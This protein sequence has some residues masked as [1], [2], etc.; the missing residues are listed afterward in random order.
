MET[1]VKPVQ[2]G[3]GRKSRW[4]AEQEVGSAAQ[5]YRWERGVSNTAYSLQDGQSGG[6]AVLQQA[7][8]GGAVDKEG[9]QAVK[10]TRLSCHRFRS[11]EVRLWL[12]LIAY[13]LGNLWRRLVLPKRIE[14]WSLTSLQQRLVKTGGRL[15]THARYYWLKGRLLASRT[16]KMEI[17]T[18]IIPLE[19]CRGFAAVI[20]FLHH[21][22]LGFSPLTSGFLPQ[23]RDESSLAGSVFFALVNGPA[24]IVLFFVLSGY[25][26]TYKVFVRG[27]LNL[28]AV[29]VLKRLPR[30]AGPVVLSTIASWLL[31]VTHSYAYKEAAA[32]TGS[33]WLKEFAFAGNSDHFSPSLLDA[34]LQGAFYT[35]ITGE[36]FYN[37]NLWTMQPEFGG[38]LVSYFFATL[39]VVAF[40]GKWLSYT[41]LVVLLPLAYLSPYLVPFM[42]G[43]G[44]AAF[45]SKHLFKLPGYGALA[46]LCVGGYLLGFIIP[47]KQYML[48]RA[49][50]EQ[51]VG[52]YISLN[53]HTLTYTLGATV[54]LVGILSGECVFDALNNKFCQFLGRISFSLY[55][56]QT[57]VVCSISS[58]VYAYL[59][60][61]WDG[62]W[63]LA[64]TFITTLLISLFIAH[65]LAIFDKWWVN[66]VNLT[67]DR[68]P[69]NRSGASV[70]PRRS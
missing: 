54:I 17:P 36:H 59:R 70:G 47:D 30:L 45:H 25:V 52:S 63:T 24:A 13:N 42:F 27:D 49:F 44:L 43:T 58:A 29:G 65:Y 48:F 53:L 68:P 35:F 32:L 38:S 23:L 20:V 3:R 10:M 21:F 4:P 18:K 69:L 40:R 60:T 1:A 33:P 64:G 37:S 14:S 41:F 66:V 5:M 11:N 46:L 67:I 9:K 51:H 16:I 6:G 26:L 22:L 28:I 31:F 57:L 7:E 56:V 2:N 8:D 62:T 12:S 39:I 34:I 55:L 61:H 15:V 19:A 50:T